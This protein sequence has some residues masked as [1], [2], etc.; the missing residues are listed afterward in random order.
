MMETL[1]QYEK[2]LPVEDIVNIAG[3]L[4]W[5]L[6][7]RGYAAEALHWGTRASIA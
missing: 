2:Q 7:L 6:T 5:S 4:L 1:T 3:T